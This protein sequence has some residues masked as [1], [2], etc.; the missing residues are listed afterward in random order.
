MVKHSEHGLGHLM[1]PED[2]DSEDSDWT[3]AVWLNL[4]Q[5]SLGIETAE[6]DWIDLPAI[7]RT[8]LSSPHL[9]RPFEAAE[10]EL[11]YPDR[12]KPFS[13]LCS[14]HV[15][16]SDLPPEVDP[17][18]FHL[19]AQYSSDPREWLNLDW[20]DVHSRRSYRVTTETPCPPGYVALLTYREVLERY[21]FHPEPK[22][23]GSDGEPCSQRTVGVL[24]RR[25]VTA[26]GSPQL[27]GKESNDLEA[28]Q[29]GEVHDWDEVLAEY[30]QPENGLWDGWI[31][32]RLK[33]LK[34]KDVAKEVGIT[35][36]YV[37]MIRSGDVTPTERMQSQLERYA[38]SRTR[39]Y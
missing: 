37:K 10:S 35:E 29:S 19:V 1:N 25:P 14:A 12:V 6:P 32:V 24:H 11:D 31:Q 20:R 30:D 5:K 26:A 2:P 22:S 17:T 3:K 16:T 9:S 28:T 38:L 33:A 8:T 36:R 15:V 4:V 13:F 21:E 7:S 18:R 23:L 34:A 39:A 27:I